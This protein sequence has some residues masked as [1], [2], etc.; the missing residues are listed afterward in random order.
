VKRVLVIGS[1]GSGKTTFARQLARRTGLPLVHLDSHYWPPHWQQ[2][3]DGEW[4][5]IV[6]E[7][8]GRDRW[9]M[10]GNY[11]GTMGERL[12]ACDTVFFLDMPRMK[13]ISRALRRQ[14]M[15]WGRSRDEMPEGC[16][17]RFS[18]E[19]LAWIW[20]YPS[21]RRG[22][23]LERLEALRTTKQVNIFRSDAEAETYLQSTPLT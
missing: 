19:F 6:R 17:E 16:N 18:P 15:N 2:R 12:E 7:L 4:S 13:C 10:D 3:P 14:F 9:I 23:I 11:G 8:I 20:T 21:R 5:A 1:G 22:A